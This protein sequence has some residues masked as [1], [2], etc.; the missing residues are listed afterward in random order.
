MNNQMNNQIKYKSGLVNKSNKYDKWCKN[1]VKE[2]YNA[3]EKYDIIPKSTID[4]I[5]QKIREYIPNKK[6]DICQNSITNNLEL[7]FPD[8]NLTIIILQNNTWDEIKRII[9]FKLNITPA[10]T[11]CP[12]CLEKLLNH[13]YCSNCSV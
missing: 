3:R 5:L 8:K 7:Y 2:K 10:L 12:I 1:K 6:Y 4:D 13:G 11:E 9:D